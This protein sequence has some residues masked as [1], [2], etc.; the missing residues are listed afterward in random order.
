MADSKDSTST[1]TTKDTAVKDTA[2][3]DTAPNKDTTAGKSTVSKDAA[4]E[5][6]SEV[7]YSKSDPRSHLDLEPGE[8]R[9]VASGAPVPD[10]P[11]RATFDEQLERREAGIPEPPV[12]G[13]GS[14]LYLTAAG[15][16]TVPAGMTPD[17]TAERAVAGPHH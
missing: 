12:P 10:G 14:D 1:S 4:V 7:T 2:V 3:K 15:Y 11:G 8:S 16:T 6:E 5:A 13:P 17:E 9:L